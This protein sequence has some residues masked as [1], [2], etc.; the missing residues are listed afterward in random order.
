VNDWQHYV[1]EC[2]L[3]TIPPIYSIYIVWIESNRV[4][5]LKYL[6]QLACVDLA[7][8]DPLQL[9]NKCR[10]SVQNMIG[11]LAPA[12]FT[13][14]HPLAHWSLRW[15]VVAVAVRFSPLSFIYFGASVR[16]WSREIPV[17][18]GCID[19]W[20]SF[21]RC[22]RGGAAAA[23]ACCSGVARNVN[24]GSLLPFPTIPFLSFPPLVPFPLPFP[25][26]FPSHPSV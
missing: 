23:G 9:P 24:W 15:S 16:Y 14:L 2:S 20:R 22:S 7:L 18:I 19:D 25:S 4:C 21:G 17:V 10:R 8:F 5:E 13:N 12:G 26:F 1:T 3:T 6:C 11:V